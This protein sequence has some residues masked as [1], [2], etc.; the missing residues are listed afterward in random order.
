M[1]KARRCSRQAR[2]PPAA[3][4]QRSHGYVARSTSLADK[5]QCTTRSSIGQDGFEQVYAVNMT[6]QRTKALKAG[7]QPGRNRVQ[8][9]RRRGRHASDEKLPAEPP[10][11]GAG[12]H[13][14]VL[15]E[16]RPHGR[17]RRQGARRL[18]E[19]AR[20]RRRQGRAGRRDRRRGQDARP[21]RRILAVR[22]AAR[23]RGAGEPRQGLSGPVGRGGQA[24]G[25]RAGAAGGRSP[26]RATSAS[27]IPNGRRT[28]ST[29]SSSRPIC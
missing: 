7:R 3:S 4:T 24:H 21:R 27:P 20:G 12:R 19:A 5:L 22:P 11:V 16:H 29:T 2:A 28:S 10:Q 15:A 25:G 13:R 14:A 9:G 26:T 1:S 18:S 6:K 17:G 23:R 8:D